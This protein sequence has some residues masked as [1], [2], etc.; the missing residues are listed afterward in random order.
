[1]TKDKSRVDGLLDRLVKLK[2]MKTWEGQLF[3]AGLITLLIAS[4][5]YT[6]MPENDISQL[7]MVCGA[8]LLVIGTFALIFKVLS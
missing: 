4:P 8:A 6:Y 1:M 7:I 5:F 3:F 2:I